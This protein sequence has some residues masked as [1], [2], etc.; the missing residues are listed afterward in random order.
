MTSSAGCLHRPGPGPG[1]ILIGHGVANGQDLIA[2]FD[3]GVHWGQLFLGFTS[4]SQG[5]GIVQSSSSA[6]MMI[7]TFDGGHHWAPV[8]F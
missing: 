2:S 1:V 5:V 3:A 8:K 6:N 4:P 7:M